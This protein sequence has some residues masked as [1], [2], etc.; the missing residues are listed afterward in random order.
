M[1]FLNII[2]VIIGGGLVWIL[3]VK[4]N[5]EEEKIGSLLNGIIVGFVMSIV[6]VGYFLIW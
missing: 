4:W 3:V 1:I 5:G 6:G 2:F